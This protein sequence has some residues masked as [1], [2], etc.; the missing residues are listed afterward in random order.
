MKNV[1]NKRFKYKIG[2]RVKTPKNAEGT[3]IGR[4][5]L[6]KNPNNNGYVVKLDKEVKCSAYDCTI[7]NTCWHECFLTKIENNS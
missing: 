5:R 1:I 7:N 6:D 3:I 4:F 2:A